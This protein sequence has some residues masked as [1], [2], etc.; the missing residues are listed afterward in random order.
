MPRW[1][2]G[3]AA[4]PPTTTPAGLATR[5]GPTGPAARFACPDAEDQEPENT[6]ASGRQT[7]A[8]CPDPFPC[9]PPAGLTPSSRPFHEERGT[10][11]LGQVWRE[12][13]PANPPFLPNPP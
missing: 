3:P 5:L 4:F 6:P 10:C 1:H 13:K 8:E 11:G 7:G 12:A 9:L 2:A